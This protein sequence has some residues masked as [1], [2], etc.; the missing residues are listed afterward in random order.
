MSSKNK[1]QRF[2]V[3][4]NGTLHI[5]NLQLQDRGQYM[6]TAQNKHGIDKMTVTL[7]VVAQQP[8]II[9]PRF[10]DILVYLGDTITM[11][12]NASGVPPA[13]ISW[14]LP[15]RR[16]LHTV[17][18]TESRVMLFSNGSLSIKD[19]TFPDRGIYKCVASN[20]AGT[21]SLTVKLQVSPLP[22]IIQQEK[23]EN[24][25]L[26]QSHSIFIHCSAKGAP[27]PTIRWV[28]LDGT[29]VRPSQYANGNLFVFPNGTLFIR[30]SSPRDIGKY[31]CIAANIVGAARRIVHL[32][33]RKF[34]SNAKITASSP[35]KTD[36]SYG[37]TL[38]LDCS[39]AGDPWPRIM[40]RLPSKRLVDSFFRYNVIL[41]ST[42]ILVISQVTSEFQ[43]F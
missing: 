31:E 8:K 24:I 34:P 3:L 17:S 35:Q 42:K 14:I 10:K 2:E 22:P 33:V 37:G 11:D 20:V 9:L 39:A 19:V 13:H 12:C 6:C 38:R 36:V 25:S 4:D 27:P 15:E 1:I 16:I 40:W 18:T 5:Q 41:F 21:D 28:L 32:D 29:Q 23:V 26:P 7:S 30:N 43:K